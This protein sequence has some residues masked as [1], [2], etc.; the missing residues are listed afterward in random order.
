MELCHVGEKIRFFLKKYDIEMSQAS[1]KEKKE[2][3][4][5]LRSLDHRP[6]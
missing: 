4:L 3:N 5:Q 2:N 1:S 6:N